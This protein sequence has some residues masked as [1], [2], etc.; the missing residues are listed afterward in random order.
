[1]VANENNSTP[2]LSRHSL[3]KCISHC[4]SHPLDIT[5]GHARKERQGDN[6]VENAFGH[7]EVPPLITEATLVIRHEVEW[8]KMNAGPDIRCA[9]AGGKLLP[10]KP[11][12]LHPHRI[13]MP[14]RSNVR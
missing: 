4:E 12:R 13:Q 8:D 3:G 7:R 9:Q 14:G 2:P 5:I 10:T 1:M 11:R 6:L